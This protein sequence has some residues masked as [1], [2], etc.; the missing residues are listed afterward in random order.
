MNKFYVYVEKTQDPNSQELPRYYV[1]DRLVGQFALDEFNPLFMEYSGCII[2]ATDASAAHEIYNTF[3]SD[4]NI[5]WAE[6]PECTRKKRE[7]FESKT[8]SL[9]SKMKDFLNV[10]NLM[11]KQANQLAMTT[12]AKSIS[13][14]LKSANEKM[15]RLA[16]LAQTLSQGKGKDEELSPQ[17]IYTRIKKKYV[18]KIN[19]DYRYD[20][21]GPD[22]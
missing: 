2:E 3:G 11:G 1:E 10:V 15:S 20:E 22:S 8:K 21:F 16:R 19:Q 4:G 14:D 7:A 17:Q 12:L 5:I 13:L 6:E 18:E 9:T